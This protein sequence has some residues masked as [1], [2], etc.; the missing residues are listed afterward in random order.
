MHLPLHAFKII[1]DKYCTTY[2]PPPF[3]FCCCCINVPACGILA[4]KVAQNLLTFVEISHVTHV[5]W[6]VNLM[7]VP[8]NK[9]F[10]AMKLYEAFLHYYS[11][12]YII[13]CHLD[14]YLISDLFH[15]SFEFV[16]YP[17]C[18]EYGNNMAEVVKQTLE[19]NY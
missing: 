18:N 13:S 7:S 10:C 9:T 1:S 16:I 6:F 15:Y 12:F 19:L 14:Q 17:N 2:S 3:L 4:Y 8:G 5:M 11:A